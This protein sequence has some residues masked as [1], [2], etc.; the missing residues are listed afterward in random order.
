MR[1]ATVTLTSL[2]EARVLRRADQAGVEPVVWL[3]AEVD[4]A[5]EAAWANSNDW[6]LGNPPHLDGDGE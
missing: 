6:E 3:Q 1:E 2:Q 5:I 4:R